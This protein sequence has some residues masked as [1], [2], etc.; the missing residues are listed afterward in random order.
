MGVTAE[1]SRKI[2]GF[3]MGLG[4]VIKK[5]VPS[6]SIFIALFNNISVARG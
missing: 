2:V 3:D 5:V 4:R 1:S 6:H